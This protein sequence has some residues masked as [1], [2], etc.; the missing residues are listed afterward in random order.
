MAHAHN[1]LGQH[2]D[3][4]IIL[5]SDLHFRMIQSKVTPNLGS[6]S[7]PMQEEL[8]FAIE[9]DFPACNGD[10]LHSN[11]LASTRLTAFARR[12]GSHPAIPPSTSTS[13]THQR[14]SL[15]G[16]SSL[17]KRHMARDINSIYREW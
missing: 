13:L 12:L 15:R 1:L 8:T 7:E 11:D 9:N 5:S 3:M 2:T 16:S 14:T 10:D 6:L 17:S 4:N